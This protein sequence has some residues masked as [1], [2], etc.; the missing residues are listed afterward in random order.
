MKQGGVKGVS[1]PI[2]EHTR[3]WLL[4]QVGETPG[5]GQG[6]ARSEPIPESMW[7]R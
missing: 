6:C 7:D 1:S 4:D 2:T 3:T 5:Y